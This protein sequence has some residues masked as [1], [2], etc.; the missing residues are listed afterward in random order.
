M[1]LGIKLLAAPLL[2]ACVMLAAGQID[3]LLS[4]RNATAER[5]ADQT[6][7]HD[8]KIVSGLQ[9][10][11]SLVHASVYRTLTLIASLDDK[12]VKTIRENLGRQLGQIKQGFA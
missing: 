6:R 2:T 1:K 8:L 3:A 11:L 5:A 9:D 12:K 4:A 7:L 10:E